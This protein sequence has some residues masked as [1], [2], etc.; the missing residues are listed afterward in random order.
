MSWIAKCIIVCEPH[1]F[2]QIIRSRPS[3]LVHEAATPVKLKHAVT[4][5][6]HE[7][8]VCV[9]V[10]MCVCAYVCVCMCVCVRGASVNA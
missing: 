6:L 7:V 4:H 8:P 2:E 10:K 1:L 5:I 9:C 3:K